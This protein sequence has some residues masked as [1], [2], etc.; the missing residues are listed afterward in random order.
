MRDDDDA[1]FKYGGGCGGSGVLGRWID[2]SFSNSSVMLVSFAFAMVH[3]CILF[4]MSLAMYCGGRVGC[5]G[6]IT[7]VE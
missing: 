5:S 7:I 3:K 2:G 4:A 6:F 1:D